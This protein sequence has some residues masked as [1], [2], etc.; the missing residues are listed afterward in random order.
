MKIKDFRALTLAVKDI[1]DETELALQY[2]YYAEGKD[3]DEVLSQPVKVVKPMMVEGYKKYLDIFTEKE[4]LKEIELNGVKYK[5]FN[6]EDINGYM[7]FDISNLIKL[8]LFQNIHKL[9]A[10]I[11]INKKYDSNL[12]EANSALIDEMNIEEL[13]PSFSF[14][15]SV[16]QTL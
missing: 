5:L 9:I 8:D 4:T 1:T 2:L 11:Y 12:I 7:W 10:S 14:F 15:L 13:Y 6:P 3:R 16:V